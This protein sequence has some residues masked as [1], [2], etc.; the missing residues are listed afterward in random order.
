MD[1][2]PE[3]RVGPFRRRKLGVERVDCRPLLGRTSPAEK[4]AQKRR[5]LC[6]EQQM[7]NVN[8]HSR[9]GGRWKPNE[10]KASATHSKGRLSQEIINQGKIDDTV[11]KTTNVIP[12]CTFVEPL[13]S[14][15]V[16]IVASSQSLMC[17]H[18]SISFLALACDSLSDPPPDPLRYSDQE[19]L[20]LEPPPWNILS[21][22]W[23]CRRGRLVA[24]AISSAVLPYRTRSV[25]LPDGRAKLTKF[26]K[27]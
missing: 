22:R 25:P 10:K 16:M 27:D 2:F 14:S 24:G 1:D 9:F 8:G 4:S 26:F 17:E 3:A 15:V 5:L 12:F 21:D 18:S 7:Q 13:V 23:R 11:A 19:S 20:L 6:K